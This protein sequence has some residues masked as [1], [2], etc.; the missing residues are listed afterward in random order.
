VFCLEGLGEG[1]MRS[2]G[3]DVH[4]IPKILEK[5]L[6]HISLVVFNPFNFGIISSHPSLP[7]S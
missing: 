2:E 7:C 5:I 4:F 3:L 6:P 1:W